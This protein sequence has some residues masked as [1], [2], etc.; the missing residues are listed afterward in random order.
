LPSSDLQLGA[1]AFP[2][3]L[4]IRDAAHRALLDRLRRRLPVTAR[5]R[6]E[7]PVTEGPGSAG[8]GDLRAWDVALDG[9]GTRVR[10]EA[11]TRLGDVQALQRR[12]GLKQRDGE[13]DCVVLLLN[14]TAHN[15]LVVRATPELRT[16]F[17]VPA[18]QA[19]A[20]LEAGRAPVGNALI[21]L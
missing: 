4:P 15:R 5:W 19:I 10:V 1:K 17:P 11:E 8:T 20:A 21:L 18:R 16:Q 13:V 6:T 7:A 12:I 2:A 14:D 3:S 9:L